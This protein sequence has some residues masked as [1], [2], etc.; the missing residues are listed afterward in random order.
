M[1]A[2]APWALL[3]GGF[4]ALA[5]MSFASNYAHCEACQ[6]EGTDFPASSDAP[7]NQNKNTVI[8]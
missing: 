1:A 5:A 7:E 6:A 2:F 8:L 3:I 4:I